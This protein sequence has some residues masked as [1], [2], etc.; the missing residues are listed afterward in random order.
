MNTR[1]RNTVAGAPVVSSLLRGT[2][3]TKAILFPDDICPMAVGAS[4]M[5]FEGILLFVTSVHHRWPRSGMR[6]GAVGC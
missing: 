1:A 4:S 5:T 2:T 6:R 3:G